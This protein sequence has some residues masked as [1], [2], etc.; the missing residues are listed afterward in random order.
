MA[1]LKNIRE[2]LI[3]LFLLNSMLI[4]FS[5]GDKEP[6]DYR[7][8]YLGQWDFEVEVYSFTAGNPPETTSETRY[9][10]GMINY[11]TV[12]NEILLE[13]LH[14]TSITL[15]IMKN[16]QLANFPTHYCHGSFQGSDSLH[17]YL[18][19]GG[20]NTFFSHTINGTKKD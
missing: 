13:Y 6:I 1:L 15:M 7:D 8:K 14:N 12:E 11:G 18:R 3:F 19:W 5:C 9:H 16:G 4:L 20:L 17:L 2:S 10:T